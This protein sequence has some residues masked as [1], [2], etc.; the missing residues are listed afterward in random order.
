VPRYESSH[1][2]VVHSQ[3]NAAAF[4]GVATYSQFRQ[5]RWPSTVA[6]EVGADPA[7]AVA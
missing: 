6:D 1:R 7:S 2:F 4:D 3:G 5:H